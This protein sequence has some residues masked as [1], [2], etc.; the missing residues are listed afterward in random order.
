MDR[1]RIAKLGRCDQWQ[2]KSWDARQESIHLLECGDS[3]PPFQG[4][5]DLNQLRL[6]TKSGDESPHSKN[7]KGRW[8]SNDYGVWLKFAG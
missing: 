1:E 2:G 3:S 5:S 4:H 6:S 8:I 7:L